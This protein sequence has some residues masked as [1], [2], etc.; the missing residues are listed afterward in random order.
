MKGNGARYEWIASA[1]PQI[2]WQPAGS[3]TAIKHTGTKLLFQVVLMHQLIQT[4]AGIHT[5]KPLSAIMKICNI[6]TSGATEH[7]LNPRVEQQ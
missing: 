5:M 1:N 3:H 2:P 4:P 7:R 6:R